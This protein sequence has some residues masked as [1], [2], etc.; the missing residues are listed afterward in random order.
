MHTRII[1]IF[2]LNMVV[3]PKEKLN[4]HIF[5]PRYKQMVNICHETGANFGIPPFI[6]RQ[7][8][9]FGTEIKLLSIEKKFPNGEMDIKT[10]GSEVFKILKIVEPTGD[11]LY[12]SAEIEYITLNYTSDILLNLSIIQELQ[13]LYKILHIQRPIPDDP[14][15]FNSFDIAHF[16]GLNIVQELSLL[17]T[18]NETERQS[19]ILAHLE[20][21]IPIVRETES[22]KQKARMNGHFKNILPPF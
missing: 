3:F 5:E 9:E 21:L 18:E 7:L 20:N 14:T 22:L 12:H 4:L 17:M 15:S 2:P 6:N 16:I 19:I 13:S 10:Q 11:K 1:P 8:T